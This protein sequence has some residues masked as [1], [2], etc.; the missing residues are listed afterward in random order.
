[1]QKMVRHM[2]FERLYTVQRKFRACI[3]NVVSI[4]MK[5]TITNV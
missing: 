4:V 1:M 2:I 5:Q 3:V